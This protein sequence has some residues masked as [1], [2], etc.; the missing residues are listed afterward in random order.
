LARAEERIS[1]PAKLFSQLETKANRPESQGK[2]EQ[3]NSQPQHQRMERTVNEAVHKRARTNGVVLNRELDKDKWLFSGPPTFLD[4]ADL[5]GCAVQQLHSLKGIG[6][7]NL[8]GFRPLRYRE[9]DCLLVR[10]HTP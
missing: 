10:L 4:T 1:L 9:D 5:I 3:L 6:F 7:D 2:V 8:A